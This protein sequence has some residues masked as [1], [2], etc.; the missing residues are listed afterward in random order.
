MKCARDAIV[1]VAGDILVDTAKCSLCERRS[2][3]NGFS[4]DRTPFCVAQC[5]ES[6]KK[7]LRTGSLCE[8]RIAAAERIY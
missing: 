3:G 2:A 6:A 1:V 7:S 8:K 4:G 5:A